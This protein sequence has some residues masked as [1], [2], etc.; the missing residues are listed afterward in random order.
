[1]TSTHGDGGNYVRVQIEGKSL[2]LTAYSLDSTKVL[3]TFTIAK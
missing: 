2:N 3:D 1:M